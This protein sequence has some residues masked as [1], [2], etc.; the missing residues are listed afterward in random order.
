MREKVLEQ[1][2]LEM[3]RVVNA[4]NLQIQRLEDLVSRQQTTRINLEKIYESDEELDIL[5]VTN[6]KNFLSKLINDAKIQEGVVENTRNILKFKQMEVN[7]A[8]KEV[9]V[10]EK[11]KEKQENKFYQHYEYVQAKEI[12]DISS[13]R[14]HRVAG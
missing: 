11:L 13:T 1:K 9:K 14:Y 5:G 7:D 10:L 2:Q 3:A 12:D 4:L 8:H 6:Y